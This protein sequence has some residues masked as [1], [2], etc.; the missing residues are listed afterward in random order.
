M[1]KLLCCDV[2]L[3][4]VDTLSSWFDWYRELTGHNVLEDIGGVEYDIQELMHK[5]ESPLDYW[6]KHDLYDNLLPIKDAQ[7]AL[8]KL[9]NKYDIIFVSSCFPEHIVSKERFL[10]RHFPYNKGFISTQ[11]KGYVKADVV[12]DDYSKYLNMF[13][14]ETQKFMI[15]TILNKSSETF[16]PMKW[17]EIIERL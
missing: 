13:S 5:H 10:N 9:K 11:Q 8:N 2:D 7:Y 3:T 14:D 1:K 15:E 17:E 4:V 16:Q 6:K 12:I